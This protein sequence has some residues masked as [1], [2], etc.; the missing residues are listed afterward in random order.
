MK[1]LIPFPTPRLTRSVVASAALS[2]LLLCSGAA[3]AN[4]AC[5]YAGQ[6]WMNAFQ[7][8]DVACSNQGPNSASCDAREA[9]QAAAMQ[10][11]NSSCP[12]LDDYCTVVRDQY[13]EAAATRSFECRQ[14]GTALDPQCQALRQAEFQQFKRFVRECM[15]F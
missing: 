15:V 6:D 5:V 12:P 3:A 2:V 11:M 1:S 14:A 7:E 10:A 13:E 9:E 4:A 8:K